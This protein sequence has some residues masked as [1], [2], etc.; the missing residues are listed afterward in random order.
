[1]CFC[2]RNPPQGH[3]THRNPTSLCLQIIT[4]CNSTRDELEDEF[5]GSNGSTDLHVDNNTSGSTA[6]PWRVVDWVKSGYP[7]FK[8]GGVEGSKVCT[9]AFQKQE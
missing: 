1:M 2:A 4:S 7:T 3:L 6:A 8:F 9:V 5:C